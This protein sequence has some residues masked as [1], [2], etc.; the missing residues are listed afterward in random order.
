M[1]IHVLK[2]WREVPKWKLRILME[3]QIE[4][5]KLNMEDLLVNKEQWVI[6]DPDTKPSAMLK[7]D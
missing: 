1:V 5:W 4:L 7:E 2:E 6:M 3:K